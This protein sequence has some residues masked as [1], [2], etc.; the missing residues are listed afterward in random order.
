MVAGA[1]SGTWTLVSPWHSL[2]DSGYLNLF[3]SRGVL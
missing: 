1:D 2:Q 3:N